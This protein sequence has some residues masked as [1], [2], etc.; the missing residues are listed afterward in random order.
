V[1]VVVLFRAVVVVAGAVVVVA[2][3]DAPDVAVALPAATVSP[4][5]EAPAMA[6]VNSRAATALVAPVTWRARRAGWG[7]RRRMGAVVVVVWSMP[8]C[9]GRILRVAWEPAWAPRR[10]QSSLPAL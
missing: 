10:L 8:R 6:P 5:P 9:S 3:V 4:A 1:V 2:A 7:R